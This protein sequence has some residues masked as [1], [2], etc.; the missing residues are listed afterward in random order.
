MT[1]DRDLEAAAEM[2]RKNSRTLALAKNWCAHIRMTRFGGGGLIEQMTGDPIGHLGLECDHAGRD[3]MSCWDLADAAIDFYDRHCSVCTV[4]KPVGLPNLSELIGERDRQAAERAR[5]AQRL[6]A[7]A[8]AALAERQQRRDRLKSGLS[9]LGATILEDIGVFDADRSDANFKRLTES[10]RLAPEHFP[11][12]LTDYVLDLARAEAWFRPAALAM[13]RH[14]G[15][16]PRSLVDIACKTLG[17]SADLASAILLDHVELLTPD[18]LRAVVPR[19]VDRAN[20]DRSRSYGASPEPQPALLLGLYKAHPEGVID[21]LKAELGERARHRVER[22][23]RGF[24]AIQKVLPAAAD[25]AARDLVSAYVRAHLLIDDLDERHERLARVSEVISGV[26]RNAPEATDVLIQKFMQGADARSRARA[27]S[28]YSKVV[29]RRDFSDRDTPPTEAERLA[30]RRLLWAATTE[31]DDDALRPVQEV[32]RHHARGLDALAEPEL[33]GL[34]GAALVM[35]DRLGALEKEPTQADNWLAVMERGNRRAALIGLMSTFLELAARTAA[36]DE[37]LIDALLETLE[38]IPETRELL[39]A[40]AIG[41]LAGLTRSLTGLSRYLS[42]LYY[43]LVGASVAG[44]ASAAAALAE[45][46]RENRK[47]IPPMVFEAFTYLLWDQYVAVHKAA[48]RALDRFSLPESL[49]PEAANAVLTILAAY[50]GKGDDQFLLSCVERLARWRDVFGDRVGPLRRLLVDT[51]M[52]IDPL[53]LR[54]SLTSL[55][56]ALAEEPSFAL[57]VIRMLPEF[58]DDTHH[59]DDDCRHVLALLPDASVQ[60]HGDRFV[61]AAIALIPSAPW[62][63]YTV[64]DRLGS[65]GTDAVARLAA[66]CETETPDTVRDRFQRAAGRFIALAYAHEAAVAAGD[67]AALEGIEEAWQSNRRTMN[68]YKADSSDRRSRAGF[69]FED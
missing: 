15:A 58:V 40:E 54:S 69:P 10:A 32:F 55:A 31:T 4:R 33:D 24:R 7:E 37:A 65:A 26:F 3:G 67:A 64:L 23:A 17:A 53:Y 62:I 45:V 13:L 29:R 57:L 34:I 8:E 66:A 25:G 50:R 60:L 56:H 35:D 68:D 20:P 16:P 22:A 6:V 2:G 47:N 28:L 39:R 42:Q 59:R 61:E 36:D 51:A 38:A 21:V 63:A 14:V 46:H 49:R 44:R 41:A 27:L 52:E 11:P 30:F 1:S 18:D 9:T 48:V 5:E 19:A 12:A 43:G